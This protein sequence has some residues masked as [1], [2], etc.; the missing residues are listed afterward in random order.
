MC[1]SSDRSIVIEYVRLDEK[2]GGK[3]GHFVRAA[4]QGQP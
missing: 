2:D 4:A 1:K 3:S